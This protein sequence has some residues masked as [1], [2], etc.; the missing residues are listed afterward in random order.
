[1]WQA[2]ILSEGRGD[3]LSDDR[4]VCRL[5]Q[6]REPGGQ[7]R[8]RG[9]EIDLIDEAGVDAFGAPPSRFHEADNIALVDLD[10]V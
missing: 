3:P 8:R 10:K 5:G 9:A 6:A 7:A 4:Q 1:M 2:R